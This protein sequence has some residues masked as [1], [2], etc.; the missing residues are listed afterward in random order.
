MWHLIFHLA[1]D[2]VSVNHDLIHSSYLKEYLNIKCDHNLNKSINL[3]HMQNSN[4]KFEL[5]IT[6]PFLKHS[7]VS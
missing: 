4:L 5:F 7:G 2:S 1:P 3:P 6:K